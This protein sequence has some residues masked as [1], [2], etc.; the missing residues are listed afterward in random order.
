MSIPNNFPEANQLADRLRHLHVTVNVEERNH[1]FY[2][3]VDASNSYAIPDW[4]KYWGTGYIGII[5]TLVGELYG[6]IEANLIA[7]AVIEYKIGTLL[8][9]I[10]KAS[11][12]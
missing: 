12:G 1:T 11:N 7:P 9:M 3:I 5:T 8:D 4:E 2:L 6:T 10:Q